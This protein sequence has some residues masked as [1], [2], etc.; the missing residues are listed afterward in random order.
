MGEREI[1]LRLVDAFL[2]A[3]PLGCS[4]EV[5]MAIADQAVAERTQG[6]AIFIVAALQAGQGLVI[7]IG[8]ADADGAQSMQL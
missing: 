2:V 5:I 8:V 3:D 6:D 4:P 1:A 7:A